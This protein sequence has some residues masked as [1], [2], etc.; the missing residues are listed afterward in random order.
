[1]I[2]SL[3]AELAASPIGAVLIPGAFPVEAAR[4]QILAAP[5]RDYWVADR[6]R[7]RINDTLVLPDCFAAL[8]SW[9]KQIMDTDLQTRFA[10]FTCHRRGDYAQPK[11][12][13]RFWAGLGASER[14]VDLTLDL[15]ATKSDEAQ[16]V[17]FGAAGSLVMPQAPGLLALV[18]RRAPLTRYER[19]L[20]QRVGE[21][22]LVRLRL[23]L[24]EAPLSA[25]TPAP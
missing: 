14:A 24:D 19:Y 22:E 5:F 11:D 21:V 18:A 17:Y 6:G 16:I 25:G 20:N 13:D 10:R 1:M 23:V 15:S 2:A 7:Y 3:R 4:A 9:V 12:D 8:T